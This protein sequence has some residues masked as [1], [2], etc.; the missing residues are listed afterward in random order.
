MWGGGE[1][2]HLTNEFSC[3]N[4]VAFT[5]TKSDARI[6]LVDGRPP[7][8]ATSRS[9]PDFVRLMSW[10]GFPQ[11]TTDM[12]TLENEHGNSIMPSDF[13]MPSSAA[14]L[15]AAIPMD[16]LNN[17]N[18]IN[19]SMNN[20]AMNSMLPNGPSWMS[21]EMFPSSGTF[22]MPLAFNANDLHRSSS[23]P[24]NRRRGM[25][26]G[27]W[28]VGQQSRDTLYAHEFLKAFR[29]RLPNSSEGQAAC[30]YC[31]KRKIKVSFVKANSLV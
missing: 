18:G 5:Q 10:Q 31:R 28:D 6:K 7:A 13:L 20:G 23:Q 21:E 12:P 30:D 2:L 15:N 17:S 26:A 4:P 8:A 22:A 16:L 9:Q 3:L 25:D 27:N 14:S 19:F 29:A 24:A 11:G 1:L